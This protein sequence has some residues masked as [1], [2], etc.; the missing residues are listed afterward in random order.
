[1]GDHSPLEP[2]GHAQFLFIHPDGRRAGERGSGCACR[3]HLTAIEIVRPNL[4]AFEPDAH[5]V[6]AAAS[7]ALL[8]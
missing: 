5:G 8:V 6:L 2:G 7:D 4:V 3:E 1:M